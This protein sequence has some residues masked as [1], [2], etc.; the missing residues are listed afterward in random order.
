MERKKTVIIIAIVLVVVAITGVCIWLYFNIKENQKIDSEDINLKQDLTVEFGKKVKVSDFIANLNGILLNDYEIDTEVLGDI[1]VDFE[2]LNIKNRKRK[3][4]F[5]IKTVDNTAPKIFSGS[6]YTVEVGYK[7]SLVDILLSGDDIDDNPKREIIG[8]YDLNNIGDY[9]LTYIVTDSSGNETSKDFILHVV[10]EINKNETNIESIYLDDVIDNYKTENTKIGIDVSKWQGE[11]NW[12]EVK[13]SG[14]EFAIIRVGYQ[15]DYDG[16]Y[17][18]DPYFIE[19]IAGATSVRTT[20]WNL[21]LLICKN[22]GP[23][24]R[25]GKLGKTA[26]FRI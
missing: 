5:N 1:Q 21:F 26:T 7:K 23:S 4:T 2:F 16:D 22:T 3:F 24:N 14:V 10:D 9:N 12:E 20:S 15:T 11:I 18:V 25:T 19:N 13:N 6:S 17:V 8:E